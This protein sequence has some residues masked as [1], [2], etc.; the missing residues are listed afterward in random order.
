MVQLVVAFGDDLILVDPDIAI[1]GKDIHVR[2]GFPVGMSLAAIGIAEGD[3]YAGK[4]FILKKNA[5]H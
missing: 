1:A 4:F 3:V 5:D 2:F